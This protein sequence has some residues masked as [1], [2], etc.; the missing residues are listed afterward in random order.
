MEK[1]RCGKFD[2]Y[3]ASEPGSLVIEV[4]AIRV[5]QC[6]TGPEILLDNQYVSWAKRAFTRYIVR[7]DR[8]WR[9]KI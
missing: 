1:Y 5:R 2:G 8:K 4:A 9:G 7:A 6:S 3:D